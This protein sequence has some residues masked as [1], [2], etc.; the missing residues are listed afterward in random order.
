[1]TSLEPLSFT[2]PNQ[3]YTQFK[4]TKSCFCSAIFRHQFHVIVRKAK[5]QFNTNL[6]SMT[7]TNKHWYPPCF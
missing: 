1:M 3:F 7:E 6:M 4:K 2:K 5:L